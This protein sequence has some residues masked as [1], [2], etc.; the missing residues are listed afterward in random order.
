[1]ASSDE[2]NPLLASDIEIQLSTSSLFN[3][4]GIV[5]TSLSI[6]FHRPRVGRSGSVVLT[7]VAQTPIATI[8]ASI[9][10]YH[11]HR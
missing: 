1:M 10:I 5:V 9:I 8:H 4:F 6:S 2:L 7:F 3:C 11:H